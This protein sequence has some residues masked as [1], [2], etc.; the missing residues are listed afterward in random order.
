MKIAVV[1]DVLL[2][3]DLR[4]GARRLSPDAPVPVVDVE[5]EDLRAGGAGLVATLLS[6]DGHRVRLVT[7]LS[8]DDAAGR[9]RSVLDGIEVVAGP[10]GAPTPV[11]TRIRA[12]GQAVVRFDEGCA[13]APVPEATAEMLEAVRSADVVIVADYGRGLAANARLREVLEACAGQVPVVWDPHPAGAVPVPG[14]AAVT[15]N[16]AE[17]LQS[18]GTG[19]GSGA[20]AAAAAA[21]ELRARWRSRALVVTMGSHG[22]LVLAE[23]G[24]PQLVPAPRTESGDPCGAGDRF[25]AS[26]AVGLGRGVLVEEAA[27]AAARDAADFLAAGGVASLRAAPPPRR[28]R[29][30][31][32]DA[33]AA[34]LRIREAGGTVVATGGCFDLLHAGHARTLSAA[35]SLGDCLIVC[36]NSDASVR[37]LKGEHRPIMSQQDRA[38]LLNSLQCV[39]G[40]LIFDEDTPE[41]ALDRLRPDIWVKGGDYTVEQLPEAALVRSWGGQIMTVPYHPARST[42]RLAEALARVG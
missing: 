33:L 19:G 35:R 40:V 29:S 9:L 27:E 38:E 5:T 22:A 34:A 25:A 2:D 24:L 37:R 6:L 39:D 20:R 32:L 8:D 16:L 42:T 21:S 1:G 13:E 18:A 12:H 26:L 36:L 31:G 41:A 28:L 23:A 11:K 17:A 3:R 14:V 7:V 15:P 10:S 30:G 4:G